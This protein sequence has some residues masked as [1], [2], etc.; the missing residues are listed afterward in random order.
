ML[1]YFLFERKRIF[2]PWITNQ[3]V[4]RAT[5]DYHEWRS[6]GRVSPL[7][8]S[9]HVYTWVCA[10]ELENIAGHHIERHLKRG[11]ARRKRQ[12]KKYTPAATSTRDDRQIGKNERKTTKK[13]NETK[14]IA[15]AWYK[16]KQR[17][18]YVSLSEAGITY[19]GYP[20]LRQ[21][22]TTF[23]TSPINPHPGEVT[24]VI[25]CKS[26]VWVGWCV[27]K[28]WKTLD[29]PVLDDDD[30]HIGEGRHSLLTHGAEHLLHPVRGLLTGQY[31]HLPNSEKHG[32]AVTQPERG[33]EGGGAW[34]GTHV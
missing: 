27:K 29:P 20:H 12:G 6:R 3:D 23:S 7:R 13:R 30:F 33:G 34:G 21:V 25:M 19:T 4:Q 9:P 22:I 8:R 15:T 26:D 1:T 14:P 16:T 18:P 24:R 32:E 28:S 2:V 10:T 17:G 5:F 11:T 31:L